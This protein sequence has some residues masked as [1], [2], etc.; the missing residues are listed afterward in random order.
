MILAKRQI[1]IAFEQAE[2][3]RK[4]I[5]KRVKEGMCSKKEKAA[6]NGITVTYGAKQGVKL[7]TKKSIAAK[8]IIIKHS[9]DFNGTLNDSDCCK[10]AGISRNTFYKYKSELK[11]ESK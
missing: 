8:D 6:A 5:C 9:K 11:A 10:L 2:K 1:E 7:T 4:D 3:E